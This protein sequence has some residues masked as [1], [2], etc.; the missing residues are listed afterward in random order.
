MAQQLWQKGYNVNK[1]ILEFTVG[2]DPELDQLMLEFDIYGS[3]AHGKML[4]KIGVLTN[5]EL[6]T[7]IKAFKTIIELNQQGKFKVTTENEDGH[8]AIENY[9]IEQ[10]GDLGKK[11]HTARSRNDQVVTM[12]RLYTK[13]KLHT[14]Y[15]FSI[16][17]VKNLLKLAKKYE[18]VPMPGYTHMQ[19][20]MPMSAGMW[21]GQYAECILDDLELLKTAYNLNNMNPLGSAA[22]FGVNMPL[23]RAYTTKLLGFKKVQNNCL[24]VSYSRGK[25]E[26]HVLYALSQLM[27]S[28]AKFS[29]DVLLFSM[30]ETGYVELPKEYCTGSSLMP[31]KKNGDVF[32]LTRGKANIMMGYLFSTM[33]IQNVLLSGY[34]RDTQLT[35]EPL[36]K[37][38]ALYENTVKIMNLVTEV[39]TINKDKCIQACSSEIFAADYALDLVKEGMPFRDAYRKTAENL[40]SLKRIDPVENIKS[41]THLGAPGNLGLSLNL[42]RANAE[43]RWIS[44]EDRAWQKTLTQLLHTT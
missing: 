42:E 5:K 6:V 31:Q 16:Q 26:A 19:R 25:I 23:D 11:I 2:N 12:T 38:L 44:S 21:L 10:L 27:Q 4:N 3:I 14:L 43:L 34:N 24:Y 41:K 20:A 9:L 8:T 30:S 1:E 32:E 37:G 39:L 7:L 22:G 40:E 28:F 15:N 18:F 17:L 13:D 33:E 36:V 29:N 35:K